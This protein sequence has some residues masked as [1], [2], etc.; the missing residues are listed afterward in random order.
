MIKNLFKPLI[1][2]GC[3]IVHQRLPNDDWDRSGH[4]QSAGTPDWRE[5]YKRKEEGGGSEC[6]GGGGEEGLRGA[7]R[8]RRKMFQQE[9]LV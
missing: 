1:R 3:S 2:K 7:G 6:V 9:E 4:G 8:E 5:C